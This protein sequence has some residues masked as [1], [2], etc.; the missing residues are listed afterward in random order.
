MPCVKRRSTVLSYRE[1]VVYILLRNLA[2][3]FLNN[4]GRDYAFRGMWVLM[5]L[6]KNLDSHIT[7]EN[8]KYIN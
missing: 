2:L 3:K 5:V 6:M 1:Q 7:C 4:R 8:H